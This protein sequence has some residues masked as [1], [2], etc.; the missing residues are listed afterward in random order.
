MRLLHISDLHYRRD[1][2][3]DRV[4]ILKAASADIASL[5]GDRSFDAVIFTGDLVYS[6]TNYDDFGSAMD[7]CIPPILD[8][9]GTRLDQLVVVP[10][11]HDID[12]EKVSPLLEQSIADGV[13]SV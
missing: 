11:N 12:R 10:G 3:A 13:N 1:S 5:A 9:S 8:A 2:D 6:G 4:E 7:L